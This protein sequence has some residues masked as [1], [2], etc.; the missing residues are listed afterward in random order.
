MFK[1]CILDQNASACVTSFYEYSGLDT[2]CDISA[3]TCE[4][5]FIRFANFMIP[6]TDMIEGDGI[7][8]LVYRAR[9]DRV[10][11]ELSGDAAILR[12]IITTASL[13]PRWAGGNELQSV[14][15]TFKEG[16]FRKGP[17]IPGDVKFNTCLSNSGPHPDDNDGESLAY[18]TAVHEAGH[19]LGLSNFSYFDLVFRQGQPYEASHPTI[20]DAVMNYDSIVSRYHPGVTSAFSE[21]DCSPHPFDVMAIYGVYN[22][23]SRP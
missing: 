12:D 17:I 5:S 8:D 6:Y 10:S 23:E 2:A 9:Y 15:V 22:P 11:F 18:A 7:Q 21:P 1:S 16:A 4:V 20:P 13:S 19:A 14:D 3:T